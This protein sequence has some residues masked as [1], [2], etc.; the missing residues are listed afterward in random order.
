MKLELA[1]II[2]SGDET[3]PSGA[4]RDILDA[5]GRPHT[6]KVLSIG[7]FIY[8]QYGNK[9]AIIYDDYQE[10]TIFYAQD[11]RKATTNEEKMIFKAMK[12]KSKFKKKIVTSSLE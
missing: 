1:D 9:K 5:V 11:I 3:R 6:K 7:L 10:T 4:S 12:D 2:I 8:D